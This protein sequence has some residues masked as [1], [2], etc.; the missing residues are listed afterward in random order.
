VLTPT[1]QI[2]AISL[3]VICSMLYRSFRLTRKDRR[4]KHYSKYR[5]QM[6]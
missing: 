2:F 6:Q 3:I 5:R 1:P 4:L